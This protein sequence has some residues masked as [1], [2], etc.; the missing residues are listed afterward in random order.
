MAYPL[1][2]V[3]QIFA[4]IFKIYLKYSRYFLRY[5][6]FIRVF[7]FIN[8]FEIQQR[9]EEFLI[10]GLYPD[11]IKY[12]NFTEKERYLIEPTSAYLDKDVL[13]L[14]GIRNS[15]KIH[16]LLRLIAFQIGSEV[17]LN[18]IAN[19]LGMSQETVNHYID[20]LEKAFEVKYSKIRKKA[21]QARF[22]NCGQNFNYITR[23]NFG[24]FIL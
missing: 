21:R 10:Y 11:I 7:I 24:K 9:L 23:D 4:P 8:V 16:Q 6:R 1:G 14:S 12:S 3:T 22:G 13:E 17:S 19:S 5:N 20:L 18:E 15:A 2:L